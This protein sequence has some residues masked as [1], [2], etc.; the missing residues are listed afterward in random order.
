MKAEAPAAAPPVARS[1][2]PRSVHLTFLAMMA[3]GGALASLAAGTWEP[4]LDLGPLHEALTGGGAIS[5]AMLGF[6]GFLVGLG[7]RMAGGCTSGH[8]LSGCSRLQPA[9]LIATASFFGAAVAV[10]FLLEAV[11][12]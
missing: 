5:V 9:S 10:S 1:T 8:G 11:A 4:S 6:G 12:T 7:T 3:V 2:A